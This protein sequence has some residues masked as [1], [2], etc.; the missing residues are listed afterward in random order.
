MK[1]V[2]LSCCPNLSILKSCHEINKACR[3]IPLG[4]DAVLLPCEYD[5]DF[6]VSLGVKTSHFVEALEK[7]RGNICGIL[8]T[9]P[10]Y[11]GIAMDTTSFKSLIEISHA[12]GVPV[13]V[14]E[15]HGAHLR[16]L[17]RDISADLQDAMACGADVSIQSSHKTLTALSQTAMLHVGREA[18]A[19][20][21]RNFSKNGDISA[22]VDIQKSQPNNRRA[23]TVYRTFQ[24]CYST[25]TSTSPNAILLASLDSTR[26]QVAKNMRLQTQANPVYQTVDTVQRIRAELNMLVVHGLGCAHTLD[27]AISKYNSRC[28]KLNSN[29]HAYIPGTSKSNNRY[30]INNIN[31]IF[32]DSERKPGKIT[33]SIPQMDSGIT[34]SPFQSRLVIDPLRLTVR[35]DGVT[36]ATD[37]GNVYTLTF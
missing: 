26:A 13:I 9:R 20:V 36:R 7:Y 37:I 35:F 32:R 14:D 4:C 28:Y 3:F 1:F 30:S 12:Y 2:T 18:F 8:I 24:D 10:S 22:K 25:F 19:C 23:K 29:S 34:T 21:Y 33:D 11:H 17:P 16:L 5:S 27:E 31:N 6:G 15:A